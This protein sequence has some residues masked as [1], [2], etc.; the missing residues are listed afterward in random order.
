[1][2]GAANFACPFSSHSAAQT[3]RPVL[4]KTVAMDP[5]DRVEATSNVQKRLEFIGAELDRLDSQLKAHQDRQARREQQVRQP[6][7]SLWPSA[8]LPG[9]GE[10]CQR[11][12]HGNCLAPLA[13]H[14]LRFVLQGD[15]AIA[16]ETDIIAVIVDNDYEPV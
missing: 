7:T 9:R 8:S 5:Q 15:T 2:T 4:T 6:K 1:M 14:A 12:W 16:A 10:G 11:R 3:L 13:Q